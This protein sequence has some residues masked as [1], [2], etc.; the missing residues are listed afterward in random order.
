MKGVSKGVQFNDRELAAKVRTLALEKV[1]AILD[2]G[3][4]H[5]MYEAVLLNL[6]RTLLPRLAEVTGENGSPI[7]IEL[8][9]V[10]AQKYAIN[11]GAG[12]NSR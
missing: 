10:T 2:K 7:V 8:S 6:T 3:E 1:Y 12:T 5:F 4:K 11:Q 9:S